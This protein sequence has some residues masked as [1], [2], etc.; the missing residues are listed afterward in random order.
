MA[1]NG[2]GNGKWRAGDVNLVGKAAK[3][4]A[5]EDKARAD[6]WRTQ[7]L[8]EVEDVVDKTYDGMENPKIRALYERLITLAAPL[9]EEFNQL[10]AEEYPAEFSRPRLVITIYPGGIPP[11]FRAEIRRAA[12][13]HINA[14]H[15]YMLAN[16]ATVTTE[17]LNETFQRGT[18][19]PKVVEMLQRLA[20]PN[21]ATPTLEAPGP[22]IGVLR[23][24]L[25]H[26]EEW[27]FEGYREDGSPLLPK[28]KAPEKKALAPPKGH[29]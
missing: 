15:R 1:G 27:G 18:D 4:R 22:A 23:R 13:V 26:P 11:D 28:P 16:S 21:R 20:V 9:V 25:P 10:V 2:S 19:N 12:A 29:T 6:A 8:A 3:Q 7:R 14:K 24:L 5:A 17:V